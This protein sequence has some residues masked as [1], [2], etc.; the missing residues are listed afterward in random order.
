MGI[1][2]PWTSS[3][4]FVEMYFMVLSGLP[5]YSA[6]YT[7]VARPAFPARP[8]GTIGV[9]PAVPRPPISVIPGVRPIIPPVVR[10]GLV[11]V[12]PAEKPQTTIYVGKIAPTADNDFMLSLLKVSFSFL[13]YLPSLMYSS[14]S[15]FLLINF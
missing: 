2:I 13:G 8:P 11:P 4:I 1:R 5:G 12:T 7:A 6:P 9:L 15:T 14:K 3:D 10:P